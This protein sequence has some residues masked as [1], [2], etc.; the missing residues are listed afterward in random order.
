MIDLTPKDATAWDDMRLA[1]KNGGLVGVSPGR[2]DLYAN[3]FHGNWMV[4]IGEHALGADF[5]GRS[6]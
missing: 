6:Q 2:P 3:V 5:V 1:D 4:A